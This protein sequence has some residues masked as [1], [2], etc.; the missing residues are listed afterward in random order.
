MTNY[1]NISVLTAYYT[2]EGNQKGDRV[3]LSCPCASY[4]VATPQLKK[5]GGFK[6]EELT[7]SHFQMVDSQKDHATRNEFPN[8][9]LDAR[10]SK[11]LSLQFIKTS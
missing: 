1:V 8:S 10:L 3:L 6:L 11:K 2:K 7:L 9:T 4:Q 5:R